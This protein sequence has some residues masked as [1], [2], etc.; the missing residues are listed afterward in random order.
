MPCPDEKQKSLQD[1]A[2]E[3]K[4][5]WDYR[6]KE[7]AKWFINTFKLDQSDEEFYDT[8]KADAE[9]YLLSDRI[10]IRGR[11]LKSTRLLEIGC[12]IGRM[13]RRFA[14]SFGEVHATD[15]SAGMINQARLN[16]RN[17][18]NVFFYETNGLDLSGLPD[19]F[20][21]IIFSAYV[22]QH[23]PSIEVIQSII[24]DACRV[25]K[26]GGLFKFQASGIVTK[27]FEEIQKNTW[28]GISFPEAEIRR[29]A[30]D[31]HVHLLEMDGL[32]KQY[33][34][35]I[36]QKPQKPPRKSSLSSVQPKIE[37]FGRSDSPL[38]KTIPISGDFARLTLIVSGFAPGEV[39]ANSMIVEINKEKVLPFYVGCVTDEFLNALGSPGSTPFD[40]LSQV[41]LGIPGSARNGAASVRIKHIDGKPSEPVF[42]E[43]IEPPPLIPQISL[44][45]NEFDGGL[46]LHASGEK[47]AFRIFADGMDDTAGIENVRVLLGEHVITPVS[48]SFV[49]ANG[50]H[51]TTVQMPENIAAGDYD[52]RIQSR[53]LLSESVRIRILG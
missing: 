32:G 13:T 24:S 30:L 11:D 51:M 1:F 15:I 23:V 14:Q 7:N 19:N 52:V 29:A 12:G 37:F 36:L 18:D 40:S 49:P 25:L 41:E 9:K 16:F 38:I 17:F 6:A 34:W 27:A 45:T 33:C 48:I 43:L 47:S 44:V 8:G 5:D 31:N 35:T 10:L 21:D 39:D 20:F 53:D 2:D 50:L 22:F 3:M 46:D 42:V 28:V 26:P 4:R